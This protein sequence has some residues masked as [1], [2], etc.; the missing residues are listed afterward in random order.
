MNELS[1]QTQEILDLIHGMRNHI[2]HANRI[3][4][5]ANNLAVEYI[6]GA[7]DEVEE[8][9]HAAAQAGIQASETLMDLILTEV[10]Y[11]SGD[12]DTLCGHLGMLEG[13]VRQMYNTAQTMRLL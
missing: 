5:A 9:L 3:D 11:F 4:G 1:V 8:H 7:E 13:L 6:E 10:E 2:E 12:R